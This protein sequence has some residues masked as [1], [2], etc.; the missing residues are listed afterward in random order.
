MK[1]DHIAEKKQA[2]VITQQRERNQRY[3]HSRGEAIKGDHTAEG[4]QSK[5]TKEQRR[6]NQR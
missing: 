2:K 5:V 3:P 6:I 1:G 4:K